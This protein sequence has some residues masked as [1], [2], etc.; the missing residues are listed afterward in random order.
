MI[1][2][3]NYVRNIGRGNIAV[4]RGLYLNA[5]INPETDPAILIRYRRAT[6][7]YCTPM[8]NAEE[9]NYNRYDCII[10]ITINTNVARPLSDREEVDDDDLITPAIY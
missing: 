6:L 3:T 10:P 1:L 9:G 4:R 7:T 5:L 8:V 2:I